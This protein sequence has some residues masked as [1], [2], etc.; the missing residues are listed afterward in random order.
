MKAVILN[1]P[2]NVTVGEFPT[3]TPKA[4]EV[5]VRVAFCGICGSDFHKVAGKKNT[6]PVRYPVPLGHEI[7]GVV[8]SVGEGVAAFRPGDRV[9]VDPNWSCGKCYYCKNGQTSFCE[10]GRGVVKGMAEFVVSPEENV[11]LLPDGLSLRDA[12]LCEPLACCLRGMDLLDIH[13]GERVALIGLGA[14]GTIM[15]QLIRRAGAGEVL[16]IDAN[17]AR[18]ETAMALGATLF[19][20]AGDG[21]AIADYAKTH[22]VGR[23]IECVGVGPA[24]ET[25]LEVAGKGATV[26]MFGVSDSAAKLPISLYDAFCKELTIKTSFVNPHTTDRALQ[27][28]ATGLLETDKI[29]AG[30]LSMEEAAAEMLSPTLSRKGKALVRID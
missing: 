6:H 14:I 17:E 24:Q 19:L 29:I 18:R 16:V 23:V 22:P 4:G 26:V 5:R 7:S 27:L 13:Q 30:E 21:A 10:N 1:G 12:A 25:A 28:L 15:L 8:E 3:P 11:Y 20:S 2:G 9:T